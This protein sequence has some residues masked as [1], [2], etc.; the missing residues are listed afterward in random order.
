MVPLPYSELLADTRR[1]P[2]CASSGPHRVESHFIQ[3]PRRRK[4]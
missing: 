3:F 4:T 2:E 1:A